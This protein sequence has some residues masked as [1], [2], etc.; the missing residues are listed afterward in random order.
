MRPIRC[1]RSD[2]PDPMRSI[3]CARFDPPDPMRS[4]LS[5]EAS[6]AVLVDRCRGKC[7][8]DPPGPAAVRRAATALAFGRGKPRLTGMIGEAAA[9]QPATVAIDGLQRPCRR[10]RTPCPSWR[11]G[12]PSAREWERRAHDGRGASF[13]TGES[14][15]EGASGQCRAR[16]RTSQGCT[17]LGRAWDTHRDGGGNDYSARTSPSPQGAERVRKE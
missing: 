11:H 14:E 6:V 1:A 8:A 10:R 17:G 5:D 12:V 16:S 15:C 13:R 2:P 7:A 4:W 9:P 3:R